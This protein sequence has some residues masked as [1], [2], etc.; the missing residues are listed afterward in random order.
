M[1]IPVHHLFYL[2]FRAECDFLERKANYERSERSSMI[3]LAR[4]DAA[5]K[6]H[7]SCVNWAD[8]DED[9]TEY[10]FSSP[11]VFVEEENNMDLSE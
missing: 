3:Q 8:R 10:D 9:E 1:S 7:V 11:L 2:A 5:K 4:E 6:V